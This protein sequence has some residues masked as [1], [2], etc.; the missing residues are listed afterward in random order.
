[1][2]ESDPNAGVSTP[3]SRK[4]DA[5]RGGAPR[6]Q[7]SSYRTGGVQVLARPAQRPGGRYLASRALIPGDLLLWLESCKLCETV[8]QA[9]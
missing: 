1:M 7:A 2:A 3:G 4:A 6:A 9:H 8:V 5:K